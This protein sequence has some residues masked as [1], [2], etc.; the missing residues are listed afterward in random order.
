MARYRAS[1]SKMG[2]VNCLCMSCIVTSIE[3]RNMRRP[4]ATASQCEGESPQ[5]S[6]ARVAA[7]VPEEDVRHGR[8]MHGDDLGSRSR[9]SLLAGSRCRR[10]GAAKEHHAERGRDGCN[11][12]PSAHDPS[13]HDT[14]LSL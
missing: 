12:E 4:S 10:A 1:V 9:G 13:T 3:A 14:L 7:V 8:C 11:E 6:V 2:S 5:S